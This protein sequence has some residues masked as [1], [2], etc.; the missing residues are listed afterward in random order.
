MDN[1]RRSIDGL[2]KQ[3][4]APA[5]LARV[6][7]Q[8]AQTH[9]LARTSISAAM[10]TKDVESAAGLNGDVAIQQSIARLQ[11]AMQVRCTPGLP[12]AVPAVMHRSLLPRPACSALPLLPCSSHLFCIGRAA[13]QQLDWAAPCRPATIWMRRACC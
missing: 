9:N 11:E 10:S 2:V 4:K 5:A 8:L 7:Q 13:C 6:S 1:A 3:G 12:A